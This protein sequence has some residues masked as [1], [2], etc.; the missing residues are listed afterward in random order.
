MNTLSYKT[1]SVN[2]ENADKKW[3][4]VDAENQ[5]VGRLASEIANL[6]RGKYKTNFTPHADCG[7]YV[8]VIN[9]EKVRFSGKKMTDKEYVHH[10]G[11]PGG[12]RFA[13]PTEMLNRKPVFVIE[14]AVKGM[15]P[16]N[17]L[18]SALFRNLHVYEG[19]EHPHQAQ[20]PTVVN[21][22]DLK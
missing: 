8:V 1:V 15:L 7:D 11:Y 14:H 21:V 4:L 18:G 20:N 13:T 12:Q 6:L 3:V 17:R 9:A 10:T 16:K 22:K 2:K 5:F 19:G